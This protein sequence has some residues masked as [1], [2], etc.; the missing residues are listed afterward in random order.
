MDGARSP[1]P[2]FRR[3]TG[4]TRGGKT[5]RAQSCCSASQWGARPFEIPSSCRNE[6]DLGGAPLGE[7]SALAF[8]ACRLG[9]V[10]GDPIRKGVGLILFSSVAARY[11]K[12]G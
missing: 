5:R 11:A 6:R 12:H 8:T 7:T 9:G 4:S 2:R 10:A 1:R 3:R